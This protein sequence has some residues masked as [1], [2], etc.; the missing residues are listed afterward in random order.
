M[1]TFD[2]WKRVRCAGKSFC[3]SKRSAC[4]RGQL[5]FRGRSRPP[6]SK[7]LKGERRWVWLAN[8]L[9]SIEGVFH[10]RSTMNGHCGV[11][12]NVDVILAVGGS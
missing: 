12:V 6:A 9:D 3:R 1:L 5:S 4:E 10:A 11:A 7:E 2:R 8:Q